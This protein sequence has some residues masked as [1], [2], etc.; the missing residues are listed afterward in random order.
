MKHLSGAQESLNEKVQLKPCET[1]ELSKVQT[2]ADYQAIANSSEAL[3][4]IEA[5]M[6]VWIKQIEQ[7][8]I[9]VSSDFHKLRIKLNMLGICF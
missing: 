5:C 6:C 4:G 8:I 9:F 2:P 1:Y 3:E 7:V